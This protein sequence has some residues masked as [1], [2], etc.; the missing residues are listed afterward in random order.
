M[1]KLE[2]NGPILSIVLTFAA[3]LPFHGN[4]RAA[5]PA[6]VPAALEAQVADHECNGAA[7]VRIR[8]ASAADARVVCEG[9]QRAHAFLTKAGLKVPQETVIEIVERLPGDMDGRAVGCYIPATRRIFL[10]TYQAFAATGTWF[11]EPV[12]PELYR[13][14]ASHEVGHAMA[15]CNAES[16]RLPLAAH[17]YVAYI[18]MFA[19]MEPRMRQRILG[20]FPGTGLAN[21]LQINLL[22]YLVDP[23][24]FAVDAW[25]HYLRKPDKAAW[26]REIVAGEV[27]PAWPSEGP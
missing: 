5:D 18:A 22:V 27:V 16:E 1:F 24:Q 11:R 3:L 17:E 25:R 12:E 23:L 4:V 9:A 15:A 13:A 2:R 21:S 14:A 7:R 8:S 6:G 10:L 19:T 20:H 26:L